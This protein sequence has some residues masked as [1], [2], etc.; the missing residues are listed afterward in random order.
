MNEVKKP[1]VPQEQT[2]DQ[3]DCP[4]CGFHRTIGSPFCA[5]CGKQLLPIAVL[6]GSA[7]AEAKTEKHRE[8]TVEL[9]L[10]G[11]DAFMQDMAEV[12]QTLKEA[13]SELAAVSK[14][15]QETHREADGDRHCHRYAI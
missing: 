12:T 15:M 4:R 3:P 9:K 14:A 8:I 1:G 6:K 5:N 7:D 2:H 10:E 13:N 11:K